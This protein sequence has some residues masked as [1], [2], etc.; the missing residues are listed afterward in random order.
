[1]LSHKSTLKFAIYFFLLAFLINIEEF[2][3]MVPA[4]ILSVILLVLVETSDT[5]LWKR[6]ISNIR[7][8]LFD[9][10]EKRDGIYYQTYCLSEY[11][12]IVR[13]EGFIKRLSS[14]TLHSGT[15]FLVRQ[16]GK[17]H[18]KNYQYAGIFFTIASEHREILSNVVNLLYEEDDIE[19]IRPEDAFERK[20]ALG[21]DI[22]SMPVWYSDEEMPRYYRKCDYLLRP[23]PEKM[24]NDLKEVCSQYSV[25][26]EEHVI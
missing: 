12:H 26:I 20:Y 24:L 19:V 15:V 14:I 18:F 21:F 9:M 8:R 10:T 5:T 25:R 2:T 7:T 6:T 3:H 13:I 4:V 23:L 11:S 1:M 17:C 16:P 22:K